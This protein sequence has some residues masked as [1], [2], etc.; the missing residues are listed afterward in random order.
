M[1]LNQELVIESFC[2]NVTKKVEEKLVKLDSLLV[3]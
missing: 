1:D 3:S 2:I